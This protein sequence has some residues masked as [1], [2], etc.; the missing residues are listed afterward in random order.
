[1]IVGFVGGLVIGSGG[2]LLYMRWKMMSQLNAMQQD[3]EGMF[4]MTDDLMDDMEPDFEVEE[5]E[6]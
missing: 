4:D 5:K 1:M 3:M 2:L 6:E